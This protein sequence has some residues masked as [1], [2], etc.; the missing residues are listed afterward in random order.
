MIWYFRLLSSSSPA[1]IAS[2]VGATMLAV[3]ADAVNG[4]AWCRTPR[5]LRSWPRRPRSW[6]PGSSHT[7]PI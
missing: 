2:I 1:L 5:F 3:G 4:G 7:W 6:S